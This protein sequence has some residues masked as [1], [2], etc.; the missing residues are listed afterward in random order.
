MDNLLITPEE[1]A[2][3]FKKPTSILVVD[4]D[5]PARESLVMLLKRKW[6]DIT[7][8]EDG[9]VAISLIQQRQFN[10]EVKEN[11]RKAPTSP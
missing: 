7:Q 10:Y 3:R 4:D 1:K 9:E 6:S 2:R 11:L 8:A 5:R